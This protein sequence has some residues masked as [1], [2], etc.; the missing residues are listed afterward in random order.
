[1]FD[2]MVYFRMMMILRI[3]LVCIALVKIPISLDLANLLVK[4][5]DIME[6]D[7]NQSEFCDDDIQKI[8]ESD[9]YFHDEYLFLVLTVNCLDMLLQI[10]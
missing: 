2:V 8:S 1:M 6:E 9:V 3:T 7:K 10:C 4:I 5:P